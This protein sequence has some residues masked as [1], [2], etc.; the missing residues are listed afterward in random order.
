MGGEKTVEAIP[1]PPNVLYREFD[2]SY[3]NTC[4]YCCP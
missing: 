1:L 4:C 2:A 3:Y